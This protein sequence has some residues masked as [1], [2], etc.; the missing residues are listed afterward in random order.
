LFPSAVDYLTNDFLSHEL[1]RPFPRKERI[2]ADGKSNGS[3]LHDNEEPSQTW[4]IARSIR[5]P[6]PPNVSE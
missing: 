2:V 5:G 3:H 6:K 4:F 1:G